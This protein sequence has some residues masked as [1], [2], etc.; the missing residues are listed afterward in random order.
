MKTF[1]G[2]G[3]GS[4]NIDMDR[5]LDLIETYEE[6]LE[7]FE[8]QRLE[9]SEF[10]RNVGVD[11]YYFATVNAEQLF[12]M[13][14]T[15]YTEFNRFIQEFDYLKLVGGKLNYLQIILHKLNIKQHSLLLI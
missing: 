13:E 3:P 5:G 4:A 14:L 6:K 2:S 11:Y 10:F 1:R 15:D 8:S 12:D 9:L 7:Y